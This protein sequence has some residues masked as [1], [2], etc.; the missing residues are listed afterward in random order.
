MLSRHRFLS[1]APVFSFVFDDNSNHI[2]DETNDERKIE[3]LKRLL[4]YRLDT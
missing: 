4:T 2:K 3:L 1:V